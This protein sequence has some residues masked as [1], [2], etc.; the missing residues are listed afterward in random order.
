MPQYIRWVATNRITATVTDTV[1]D[2]TRGVC[3]NDPADVLLVQFL[4]NGVFDRKMTGVGYGGRLALDGVFGRHTHYR[5]LLFQRQV[6]QLGAAIFSLT[7]QVKPQAQTGRGD[8]E[9]VDH[10]N[11]WY[12]DNHPEVASVKD[13]E[14]LLPPRLRTLMGGTLFLYDT[15]LKYGIP[16]T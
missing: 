11:S 13:F 12:F 8:M 3:V 15:P 10:L 1:G 14:A 5:L 16:A 9:T 7:G 6:F 2:V 4:L